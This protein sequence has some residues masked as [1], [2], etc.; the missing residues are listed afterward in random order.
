MVAGYTVIAH[1]F[2]LFLYPDR[3]LSESI[4]AA[5]SIPLVTFEILVAL[6]TVAVVAGWLAVYY[7]NANGARDEDRPSALRLA[8]YSLVSREFYVAD[9]YTW[10]TQAVL[11]LSQR[12]N[13]WSRWV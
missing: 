9:V 10:L 11:G 12:L 6:L 5:A 2:D 8:F 4:Y 7:T 13:V 1:A 3:S